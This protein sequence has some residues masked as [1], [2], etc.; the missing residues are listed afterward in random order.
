MKRAAFRGTALPLPGNDIDTDRIIPARFLKSIV[1]DG[2]GEHVFA[3]DRAALERR[4]KQHPFDD[5]AYAGATLL[6]VGDNFGCGSSREHAPQAIHRF[7]IDAI[8]GE[9]FAEIFFGN[10]ISVGMPCVTASPADLAE[11]MRRVSA[12]P[13]LPLHLDL[14]SQRLEA[15]DLEVSVQIPEGPRTAFIEGSWDSTAELLEASDQVAEVAARLP[16]VNH[17]S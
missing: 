15:G 10:C 13:K 7:G 17:W 1:F 6:L 16:Y 11:V 5:P 2:L 3:D 8:V 9:S 12:D 14:V 4:G